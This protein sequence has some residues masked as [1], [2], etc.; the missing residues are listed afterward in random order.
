MEKKITQSM[1]N[2]LSAKRILL[3]S[4]PVCI[5]FAL[6]GMDFI[7]YYTSTADVYTRSLNNV[8]LGFLFTTLGLLVFPIIW[9]KVRWHK[10]LSYF[11]TK[12]GDRK[13]G[14]IIILLFLLVTPMFYFSSRDIN[15]IN[16]YP[17]AKGSLSSWPFFVFYELLYVLFYYIPYEFFF[18]GV[19]QSGLSKI[20]NKW[21]S[22][23]FVTLLTTALHITKP[24]SEIVAA[25]FAGLFI[26]YI[27]EKT[28]SWYYGFI[29]HIIVGILTDVFCGL[30]F[31]GVL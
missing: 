3:L 29:I 23:I 7:G 16:T 31:L 13:S 25:A 1:D 4:T 14:I 26:G 28:G 17:L 20:W 15:M 30:N 22:I 11:G 8:L 21:Q 24:V 5:I 2:Y 6:S 10:S 12:I 9:I 18:R 19:L 27:A